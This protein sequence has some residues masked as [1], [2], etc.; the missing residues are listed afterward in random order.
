MAKLPTYWADGVELG[1]GGLGVTEA[2]GG[3]VEEMVALVGEADEVAAL[4]A[5][6]VR[7]VDG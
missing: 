5:S 7:G 3:E 6:L 2:A 4:V 1:E